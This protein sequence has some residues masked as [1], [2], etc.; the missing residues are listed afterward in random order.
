[1]APP[2]KAIVKYSRA[3]QRVRAARGS[4][5][6]QECLHCGG[7]AE[8]W[9]YDHTDPDEL[10]ADE[11]HPYSLDVSRY[12]PLCVPCHRLYDHAVLQSCGG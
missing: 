7:T 6:A 2:I 1:M 11:G 10:T 3:H 9:A 4:A 8:H 5:R 12:S